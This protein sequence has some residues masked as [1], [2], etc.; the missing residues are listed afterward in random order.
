MCNEKAETVQPKEEF[1]ENSDI[2]MEEG[3]PTIATKESTTGR[4]SEKFQEKS[5]ECINGRAF[6]ASE[7]IWKRTGNKVVWTRR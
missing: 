4:Y 3:I 1:K 7:G 6:V 2:L 5:K